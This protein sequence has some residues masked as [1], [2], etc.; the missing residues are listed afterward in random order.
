MRRLCL[1]MLLLAAVAGSGCHLFVPSGIR[2]GVGSDFD[3]ARD[4]VTKIDAGTYDVADSMI[5]LRH[6]EES[7][8]TTAEYMDG[9]EPGTY[10]RG[11]E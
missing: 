2:A 3:Y 10:A 8:Q 11:D 6:L 4:A 7:L 1:L 9:V 5:A